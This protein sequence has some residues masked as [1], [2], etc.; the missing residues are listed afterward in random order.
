MPLAMEVVSK[1][2]EDDKEI[3]YLAILYCLFY[4]KSQGKVL[5]L[6]TTLWIIS[7]L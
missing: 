4:F 1:T 7:I 5:F 2:W 3:S 6:A